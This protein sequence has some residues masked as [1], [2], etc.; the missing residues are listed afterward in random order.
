[1]VLVIKMRYKNVVEGKFISRPNRFIAIVEIDGIEETVHVKNTGRCKEILTEGARVY[2]SVSSNPLRK[3]KYDLIAVEKKTDKGNILINIDSQIPNDCA[4]E[5]L[6]MGKTFPEN[7]AIRR[8]VTYN[9][10]RF[11]IA[12]QYGDKKAF[13]EV[14]GVT[15]ER[16]GVALFPDAPTERGVKHIKELIKAK[17]EGYDAYILFVI[18]MKGIDIFSPNREMHKEFADILKTAGESGVKILAFD[19]NVT[20]QSIEID[21]PVKISL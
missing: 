13:V 12:V 10:S 21:A 3:T 1:M 5:F 18:Q 16:N 6:A 7:T 19:C 4:A 9:N 14:K 2:L 15:L 20:A 8:E 17:E 11:D